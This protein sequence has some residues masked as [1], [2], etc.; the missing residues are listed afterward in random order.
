MPKERDSYSYS[1]QKRERETAPKRGRLDKFG[2][3]K[4]GGN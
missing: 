1:D 4:G 3:S 2:S